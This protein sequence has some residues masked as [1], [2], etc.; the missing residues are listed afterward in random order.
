MQLLHS[1]P[2]VYKD[3]TSPQITVPECGAAPTGIG[4]SE[5]SAQPGGAQ[6]GL[7]AGR[8]GGRRC[9]LRAAPR[10]DTITQLTQISGHRRI[11][12]TRMT[13]V[14]L[15]LSPLPRVKFRAHN[16]TT[17][18]ENEDLLTGM[19][20]APK[21]PTTVSQCTDAAARCPWP[22]STLSRSYRPSPPPPHPSPVDCLNSTLPQSAAVVLN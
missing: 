21:L 7:A 14:P 12:G 6:E 20:S 9:S 17:P 19:S 5:G 10:V 11:P 22:T 13:F 8:A 3:N 4:L 16:G 2:N 18:L 15:G 1:L